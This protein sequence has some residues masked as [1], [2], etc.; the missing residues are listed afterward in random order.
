MDQGRKISQQKAKYLHENESLRCSLLFCTWSIRPKSGTCLWAP[1]GM[2][3]QICPHNSMIAKLITTQ[4]AQKRMGDGIFNMLP[5]YMKEC[6]SRF[7]SWH[8]FPNVGGC[9]R[10]I[11]GTQVP[12]TPNTGEC[13][14]NFKT[15]KDGHLCC[16]SRVCQ[17]LLSLR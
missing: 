16:V 9:I 7:H 4:I 8:A 5:N 10:C 6:R 1:Q 11:D 3:V 2:G 15:Y 13:E 17:Q 14:E 12:Y